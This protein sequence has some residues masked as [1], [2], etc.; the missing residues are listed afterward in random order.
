MYFCI[1]KGCDGN[2]MTEKIIVSRDIKLYIA[3]KKNQTLP[4]KSPTRGQKSP[5]KWYHVLGF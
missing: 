4:K 2:I 3:L 1:I 5:M